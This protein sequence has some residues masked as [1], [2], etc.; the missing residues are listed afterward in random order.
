MTD[1]DDPTSDRKYSKLVCDPIAIY[2][3]DGPIAGEIPIARS[4]SRWVATVPAINAPLPSANEG[5]DQYL[6][7]KEHLVCDVVGQELG[8]RL[9][10]AGRLLVR[11]RPVQVAHDELDVLQ[12]QVWASLSDAAETP[13]RSNGSTRREQFQV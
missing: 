5:A 7:E 10:L 1:H 8:E 2:C 3:S 9:P 12:L 13:K 6:D 11:E 4:D